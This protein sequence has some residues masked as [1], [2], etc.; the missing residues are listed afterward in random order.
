MDVASEEIVVNAL[1]SW[2]EYSK[3]HMTHAANLLQ[4]IKMQL[5]PPVTLSNLIETKEYFLADNE[6]YTIYLKKFRHHSL[7]LPVTET[8]RS[9]NLDHYKISDNVDYEFEDRQN[10]SREIEI[11]ERS[12]EEK[13]S[14]KSLDLANDIQP[15]DDQSLLFFGGIDKVS[16]SCVGVFRFD[17]QNNQWSRFREKML[18]DRSYHQTVIS[19]G[20][21]FIIGGSDPAWTGSKQQTT[22]DVEN[23]SEDVK[24][25]GTEQVPVRSCFRFDLQ[26]RRWTELPPMLVP[27][28]SHSCVITNESWIYAIGGCDSRQKVI[29]QC[30]R[31]PVKMYDAEA[32][33]E[34]E[35][36]AKWLSIHPLLKARV[37]MAVCYHLGRI[38]AFGGYC[39]KT[40]EVLDFSEVYDFPSGIWQECTSSLRIPRCYASCSSIDGKMYLVG[41][42]WIPPQVEIDN[43]L[44]NFNLISLRD[45]DIYDDKQNLWTCL[46]ALETPRH[47]HSAAV[48]AGKRL[49]FHG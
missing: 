31:F 42:A 14:W 5:I 13:E 22:F 8:P 11:S 10:K 41:G 21:V 20:S 35:A 37:G 16:K 1:C 18:Y 39:P 40:G 7:K 28:Y 47:L 12:V 33:K 24:V 19:E 48:V 34:S 38:F 6:C 23:S 26:T 3:T 25:S 2:L 46:T 4:T 17:E 36:G 43:G 32:H 15:V 49:Y 9:K 30:E 27:R 44:S 45:I 29:R